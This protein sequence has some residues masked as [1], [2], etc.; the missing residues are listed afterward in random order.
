MHGRGA[1]AAPQMKIS[2]EGLV[3]TGEKGYCMARAS[4]GADVRPAA[5]AF[6]PAPT[7]HFPQVLPLAAGTLR[8]SWCLRTRR[9]GSRPHTPAW[10]GRRSTATCRAPWASTPFP[11]RG[12]TRTAPSSTSGFLAG[13]R[14]ARGSLGR[15]PVRS[16]KKS[17]R[18][19]NLVLVACLSCGR[20]G[21][22]E[23]GR[24]VRRRLWRG[25][26]CGLCTRAAVPGAVPAAL[27]GRREGR[28]VQEPGLL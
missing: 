27:P 17:G 13:R 5:R 11:S 25:R 9:R 23:P 1:G 2:D 14:G 6:S 21:R 3:V 16:P 10:A 15:R 24:A 20:V 26:R 7:R 28:A 8:R 19:R 12:A 4:H 22:Q 18:P